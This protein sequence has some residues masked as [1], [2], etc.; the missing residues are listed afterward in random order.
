MKQINFI[1][2]AVCTMAA[3]AFAA[4]E[5][6]SP[7]SDGMVLQRGAPV[8][9][10][11]FSAS[12]SAIVQVSFG[13]ET[14]KCTADEQ[15]RWR[16]KLPSFEANSEPRVFFVS[17][18]DESITIED[19]VVGEVWLCAG[20]S[21]MEMA[22][23]RSANVGTHAGRETDGY[24]DGMTVD[25][26]QV[27]ALSIPKDWSVKPLELLRKPFGWRHFSP[28]SCMDLSAIA[29]HY[30]LALHRSLKVP[31]GV[32][33]TA[34]GGTPAQSW[35]PNAEPEKVLLTEG[36]RLHRQPR[37]LWNAMVAPIVPYAV[38][39]MI[40]YQGEDNRG[41]GVAYAERLDALY[42]G[43]SRAFGIVPLPFY[44]AEI[45][46]F[47][48]RLWETD[49]L[50]YRTD[51]REAQ[52]AF[53][54]TKPNAACVSTVD[55]GD[56]ESIHPDNKRTVALRL[57]ANALN[58][59]YGMKQLACDGP[60]LDSWK[61]VG[62][63]VTLTF[64]NVKGW[65]MNG[66]G[67]LPFELAGESGPFSP[68]SAK[69]VSNNAIE[70]SSTFV[71]RPVRLRYAWSWLQS[72]RLKNEHGYPLAPFRLNLNEKGDIQR[73]IDEA[74]ARGGG[75]VVVPAG[76]HLVGQIDLRSNVELHLEKGAVLEGK[77]GIEN[78]RVTKLPYSEG[79]WSAVVSAIGVTN[80]AITGEGKIFGNGVAWPMPGSSGGNQEGARPRGVF[81]ADCRD[82]RLSDF[83]LRDSACWG[84][85]FK[86]CDGVEVRRLKVDSHANEN[87]DGI[88]VE[89]RNVV[90]ADCDIDSGDDAVCIKSNNPGFT[91]ENVLVTNVVARS[92]CSA[93]KLGTASHG[94]MRDILFIDCRTEAPRRDFRDRRF[95]RDRWRFAN[96]DRAR[97]FP[98]LGEEEFAAGAG[99]AVGNVDGGV[100]ENVTFRRISVK[101]ACV[102]LFVRAG[103]RSGRACGTPPSD[104]RVFRNILLENVSGEACSSVASSITGVDGC[105]VKDITLR[106]VHI[107]CR[108]GG[109]TA[110]ARTLLVPEVAGSYPDPHMFGTILPAYGLYA[111]HVDALML[112]N[113]SFSLHPTT[114]DSRP[115]IS[116][117]DVQ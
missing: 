95:G 41:D 99:I 87:N 43:W 51:I 61:V 113:V 64:R 30:A 31:V 63:T 2:V 110:A 16:V 44:M 29:F 105:R 62:D 24:F 45:A 3:Q 28:G 68:A 86:C 32:I 49:D 83:T 55:V 115:A 14:A 52:H 76:R 20:Q 46:P 47:D 5:L 38:R 4:L 96:A 65:N 78:Y 15:G 93:L 69:I 88:D 6:G 74:A 48:Y 66:H 89:A 97:E 23:W 101:G 73:E 19:V 98:G 112:D 107:V 77:V 37:V 92:C 108:G 111:R 60:E 50:M 1:A 22:L 25:E 21:N 102:P 57:A 7:F 27:R 53:V 33:V 11:G 103:T 81:F 116:T 90:I 9:V 13:G 84:V 70:V 26:P 85:V 71:D 109:D 106:N 72:S 17:S 56:P 8:S 82:V 42:S 67:V 114:T 75:K 18:G 39:G 35:T 79:A 34:W 40:W 117:E 10:W 36:A 80:V 58:K 54:K 12:P 91:V 94:T 100:V 104:K 59:T